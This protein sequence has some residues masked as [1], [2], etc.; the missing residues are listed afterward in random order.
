M[1]GEAKARYDGIKACSETDFT[2]DQKAV[3]V[4]VPVMHGDDDQ[5][6]PIANATMLSV[7]PL[8]HGS[9]RAYPGYPHGMCATHHDW[10]HPDLLPLLKTKPGATSDQCP[11][12]RKEPCHVQDE[13]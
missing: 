7:K 6:V 1:I 3:D 11:V 8:K 2:G 12:V 4:P 9:L 10:I 5:I 13:E